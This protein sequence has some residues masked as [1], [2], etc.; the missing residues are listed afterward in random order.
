[1]A[2]V[3]PVAARRRPGLRAAPGRGADAGRDRLLVRALLTLAPRGPTGPGA[4]GS[5][6]FAAGLL[7]IAVAFISPLG[8]LDEELVLAH[9]APAP[10]DRRHRRAADRARA[11]R[12]AAAAAAREP[13]ARAGCATSATRWSRCRSGPSTST[14]GTS[15]CSTR[16]R[17]STARVHA[18]Q[19]ACFIGF[20]VL[21]WMPLVGPLPKPTWFGIP[22]KIGYLIGVR[23]TGSGARQRPHVVGHGP[24]SRLRRR[25][26]RAGTS[27]RSPTRA[28]PA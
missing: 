20:G 12:P 9:M 10:A 1:M 2:D 4:G 24:L 23:F 11:D 5:L 8:H 22:A 7:L 27:R 21:M 13:L 3:F 19:H 18:L 15:P 17:L 26:R 28:S 6:C 14:S 25:A 16:R